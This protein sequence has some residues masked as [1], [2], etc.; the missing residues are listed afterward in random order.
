MNRPEQEL[1][2]AVVELLGYAAAPGVIWYAVPNGGWRSKS[3]AAIFAGLGVKPG[4]ADFALVLPGGQAAFLELKSAKGRLSPAQEAFAES[5]A[6]AG[7]LWAVARDI[8]EAIEALRGWGA[9]RISGRGKAS[10]R[11]LWPLERPTAARRQI[12]AGSILY[13]RARDA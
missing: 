9:V 4:V 6:T 1:Q 7:A 12:A 5:C 8:D 13:D 10:H 3:E 2:R 11:V